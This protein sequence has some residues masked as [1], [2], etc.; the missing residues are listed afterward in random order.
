MY[1]YVIVSII[2]FVLI[3]YHCV[4]EN[5]DSTCAMIM[6]AVVIL[7]IV[8]TKA[9]YIIEE[10]IEQE[11]NFITLFLLQEIRDKKVENKEELTKMIYGTVDDLSK[12]SILFYQ[13]FKDT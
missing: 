5:L 3:A 13:I 8:I 1:E 9:V 7:T 11:K 2:A 12:F 10:M 6:A 4:K